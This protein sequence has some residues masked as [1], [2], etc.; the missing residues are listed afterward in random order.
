M[1]GTYELS[2][3]F[4]GWLVQKRKVTFDALGQVS[5]NLVIS[6][7]RGC[8][9]EL[10]VVNEDGKAIP[11]A[12][13]DRITGVTVSG[14]PEPDPIGPNTDSSGTARIAGLPTGTINLSVSARH[15][16]TREVAG[17]DL[18]KEAVTT[19]TVILTRDSH[20]LA[21]SSV[22]GR[23]VDKTTKS[24]IAGVN[25]GIS[26]KNS[27]RI[28]GSIESDKNGEFSFSDL[29]PGW[30]EITAYDPKRR[31]ESYRSWFELTPNQKLQ[32]LIELVEKGVNESQ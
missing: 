25:I 11:N 14:K 12:T 10:H 31:S 1:P 9:L 30:Y 13:L 20:E 27:R 6:L 4:P 19:R 5:S 28:S 17:I 7:E 18:H 8:V 32:V 29:E 24:G 15:Y 21:A 23:V 16:L 2:A 22:S 26:K 3:G